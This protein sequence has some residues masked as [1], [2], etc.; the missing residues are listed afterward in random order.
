[1]RQR[2]RRLWSSCEIVGQRI[3][4]TP[5]RPALAACGVMAAA[6]LVVASLSLVD[7]A[8]RGLSA[9]GMRVG[10]DMA[11]VRAAPS[12]A[13]EGIRG[14]TPPE[15]RRIS[16]LDSVETAVP[17]T[18]ISG[19]VRGCGKRLLV[20]IQGA[21]PQHSALENLRLRRGRFITDV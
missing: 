1:M 10:S 5:S 21:I 17:L 20:T 2:W 16:S 6:A 12:A 9:G 15:A 8:F 13:L 19:S 11:F 4:E 7:A 18:A 3:R 14:L